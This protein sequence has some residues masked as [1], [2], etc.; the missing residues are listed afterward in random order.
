MI[1][2]SQ[3]QIKEQSIDIEVMSAFDMV[4]GHKFAKN[5]KLGIKP[6]LCTSM[7]CADSENTK[8]KVTEQTDIEVMSAKVRLC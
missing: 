3:H 4:L 1:Q 2:L 5:H 8:T 6:C 7:G